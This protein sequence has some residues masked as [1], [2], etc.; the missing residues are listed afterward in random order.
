M[1]H[2]YQWHTDN[3]DGATN[4]AYDQA[5]LELSTPGQVVFRTYT[6][7]PACLS[8]GIFQNSADVN[9]EEAKRL[10]VDIVRRP[11]GGRAV[12]HDVE[13]TYCI[14]VKKPHPLL[15]LTVLE[16]Y[17]AIC[18]AITNCLIEIGVDAKLKKT[19][20]LACQQHPVLQPQHFP[21]SRQV[22]RNWLAPPR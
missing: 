6:W 14:T 12:L 2:W 8:L 18:D 20:G 15:D 9:R 19:M 10:G 21:I 5:T 1:T 13:L 11:T 7:K 16:S 4:M 3:I 17:Y 22:A